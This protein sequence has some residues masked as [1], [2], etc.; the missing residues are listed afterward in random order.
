MTWFLIG[1]APLWFMAGH[2]LYGLQAAYGRSVPLTYSLKMLVPLGESLMDLES[3]F[4]FPRRTVGGKVVM[5]SQPMENAAAQVAAMDEHVRQIEKRL[6][7][8]L[9]RRVHWVRGPLLGLQGKAIVGL[10]M[11][12]RSQEAVPDEQGLDSLDRHEVAHC[13]INMLCPPSSEPPALLLEGWAEA[14]SGHDA[15]WLADR[16]WKSRELGQTLPLQRSIG[17]GLGGQS[18]RTGLRARWPAGQ[19]S[20]SGIRSREVLSAVHFVPPIHVRL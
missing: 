17:T 20:A 18:H 16:A 13:V 8:Q 1:T 5:I 3:R 12:T 10:C 11:G 6:G 19:L 14:N 2:F 7:R 15:Q 9:E 4:R